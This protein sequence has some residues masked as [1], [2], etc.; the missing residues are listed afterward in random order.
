M[1]MTSFLKN[2]QQGQRPKIPAWV[3]A[4]IPWLVD[5]VEAGW[6]WDPAERCTSEEMV[7]VIEQG[8]AK[9]GLHDH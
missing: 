8:L 1:D 6:R 7:A 4:Q 2:I 3:A 9:S 5:V